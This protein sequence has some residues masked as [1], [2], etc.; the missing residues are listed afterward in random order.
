M[1]EGAGKHSLSLVLAHSPRWMELAAYA[2]A[3]FWLGRRQSMEHAPTET[4]RTFVR[5]SASSSVAVAVYRR[6]C[7]VCNV[8]RPMYLLQ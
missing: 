2:F 5:W 8:V 4:E 1:T 6:G 7:V 3:W